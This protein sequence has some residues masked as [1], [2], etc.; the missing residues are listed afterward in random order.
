MTYEI[1]FVSVPRGDKRSQTAF[2]RK[3]IRYVGWFSGQRKSNTYDCVNP[4]PGA[5]QADRADSRPPAPNHPGRT[6]ERV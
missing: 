5:Q 6:S 3:S 1:Y 4:P 2:R